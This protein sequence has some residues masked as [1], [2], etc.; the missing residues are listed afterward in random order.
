MKGEGK[1]SETAMR[2]ATGIVAS[3]LDACCRVPSSRTP[4]SLPR[5]VHHTTRRGRPPYL[6]AWKSNSRGV[7]DAVSSGSRWRRLDP[8]HAAA[9][10]VHRGGVAGG[11]A[12]GRPPAGGAEAPATTLTLRLQKEFREARF[13]EVDYPATQDVKRR[14]LVERDAL[15]SNLAL[16]PVDFDEETAEEK[17][18]GGARLRP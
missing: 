14:A 12:P 17:L 15:P 10:A 8:V 3:R 18:A 2:V 11:A 7:G 16:I 4:T 5:V 6:Q 9:E 1:P 13:Y